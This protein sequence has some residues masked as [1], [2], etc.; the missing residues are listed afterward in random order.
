MTKRIGCFVKELAVLKSNLT[1]I[2]KSVKDELDIHLDS[3]NQNTNEIQSNYETISQMEVK[4]DKLTEKIDEM[5]MQLNPNAY[6]YNVDNVVLSMREQELF[7][8]IYTEEDRI[9]MPGLSRKLGLTLPMCEALINSIKIKG[10]P[11]VRQLVNEVMHV[12]LD[13]T[14]KDLQAR[15]NL[16]KIDATVTQMMG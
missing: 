14:F 5:Q 8:G 11:I 7:L 6:M 1:G 10:V 9:S 16:L 3:I 2:F 4:I 12:S 13:Y 15:K